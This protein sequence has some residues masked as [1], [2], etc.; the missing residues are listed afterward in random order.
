MAGVELSILMCAVWALSLSADA[1]VTSIRLVGGKTPFSGRLEVEHNRKWGTVCADEFTVNSAKVVCRMLGF[2]DTKYAEVVKPDVFGPGSGVI[3]L[4]SLTCHGNESDIS[5]CSHEPWGV[6]DCSPSEDIGVHCHTH[7]RLTSGSTTHDGQVEVNI[8]GIWEPICSENFTLSE[9]R[10]VCGMMGFIFN[11]AELKISNIARYNFLPT[12]YTCEGYEIDVSMCEKINITCS[13]PYAAFV[14]CRTPIRLVNG[15]S[16]QSGRVEVEYRG[17]WGTICDDG[18]DDLEAKVI[19]RMLDF[20]DKGAKSYGRAYF[21]AGTGPVTI[22]EMRCIGTENDI[23]DCK[24]S[25]WLSSKNCGH[26]EDASVECKTEVRL[27]NGPT[28]FS[29]RLEIS[30]GSVWKTVCSD[31][32]DNKTAMVVCKML[33]FVGGNISVYDDGRF[34]SGLMKTHGYDCNGNETDIVHCNQ[35]EFA[36][37]CSNG[38]SVGF[39]CYAITPIRLLEGTAMFNGRIEIYQRENSANGDWREICYNHLTTKD[40]M[41]MCRMIGHPTRYP[42]IHHAFNQYNSD[43]RFPTISGFGCSG[44]ETDITEC[45]PDKEWT[46]TSCSYNY[47]AAINCGINSTVRVMDGPSIKAG[48]VEVL[49]NGTWLGICNQRYNYDI[50]STDINL[51]CRH[52]GFNQS[53]YLT[54]PTA[55]RSSKVISK[56]AC[57]SSVSDVSDCRSGLWGVV[58]SCP[59]AAIVCNS[60]IRLVNGSSERSGRVEVLH[61]GMWGTVCADGFN[62]TEADVVCRK[63]GIRLWNASVLDDSPFGSGAHG[64]LLNNVS[65]KSSEHDIGECQSSPWNETSCED[66]NVATVLCRVLE[67]PIRLLGGKTPFDGRVELH[68]KNDWKPICYDGYNGKSTDVLCRLLQYNFSRDATYSSNSYSSNFLLENLRCVGN[69]S[70]IS[71]CPSSDWG[72]TSC[73]NY[74]LTINCLSPIF[75]Y[76]GS[77]SHSGFVNV[78]K[79]GRSGYMCADNLT[80]E[81]QSVICKMLF[82][83]TRDYTLVDQAYFKAGF[84]SGSFVDNI[85]CTG[86]EDDYQMCP[87]SDWF[88]NSKCKNPAFLRCNT[89]VRLRDGRNMYTGNVEVYI[90]KTWSNVCF[91]PSRNAVNAKM[92]CRM[93]GYNYRLAL[94]SNMTTR[95]ISNLLLTCGGSADDI[96]Q[97]L[98]INETNCASILSISCPT[99]LQLQNGRTRYMGQIIVQL[100]DYESTVNGFDDEQTV[101]TICRLLGFNFTRNYQHS[102]TDYLRQKTLYRYALLQK[103]KCFGNETDIV[104]C[105]ESTVYS[106]STGTYYTHGISCQTP[107]QLAKGN[108]FLSGKLEVNVNKTWL[109]VCSDGFSSNDAYVICRMLGHTHA[110]NATISSEPINGTLVDGGFSCNGVE[111]DISQCTGY[112]EKTLVECGSQMAIHINCQTMVRLADGP[113]LTKGRVEVF[114]NGTWGP[115][116]QDT[117]SSFVANIICRSAGFRYTYGEVQSTFTYSNKTF[118]NYTISRLMCTRYEETI[119]EC[120]SN[121]WMTGSCIY[122][123]P[124]EVECLTRTSLQAGVNKYFGWARLEFQDPYGTKYGTICG[125]GFFAKE[126]D[127]IC[128][129]VGAPTNGNATIY[130][131]NKFGSPSYRF[132]IEQLN[133][134]GKENDLQECQSKPWSETSHMCTSSNKAVAINCRPNTPIRLRGNDPNKGMVE[135]FFD[136]AWYLM[137]AYTFSFREAAVVCNKLGYKIGTPDIR[138]GF[139]ENALIYDM[140]CQGSETDISQCQFQRQTGYTYSW[141]PQ[142]C[143]YHG[144]TYRYN[145]AGVICSNNR[146]RLISNV[147]NYQ[148]RVEFQYFGVW[149]TVCNKHFDQGDARVVCRLAGIDS[150]GNFTIYTNVSK[151]G[152]GSG[153]LIV[154]D[155][156]CNGTESDIDECASYPW[157][158]NSAHT[159][160]NS[161]SL[162]VGVN[163]RPVT[164]MRL[165][166]GTNYS[167]RVEI[168]YEGVW[169]T[170]CDRGFDINDAKVICRMKGFNTESI[171]IR[172]NGFYGNGNGRIFISDLLC[173]GDEPD[174]SECNVGLRWKNTNTLCTN[175]NDVAVQCNT[176]VRVRDGLTF[177]SGIAEVYIFGGWRRICKDNFTIQDALT[178]CTLAGKRDNYNG[179]VTIHNQDFVNMP[180]E[181]TPIGDF[182]CNSNEEDLYECG[183]GQWVKSSTACPSGE[184]VALNCRAQ[185]PV[186]LMEGL[187]EAAD[188]VQKPIKGRVEVQY[189]RYDQELQKYRDDHWG[190]ICDDEFGDDDALVLCSMMGYSVGKVYRPHEAYALFG[191]ETIILDDLQCLGV[192]EDVS[193]CKAREWGT[194]DCL[195]DENVAIYCNYQENIDPCDKENYKRLPNLELRLVNY[196]TTSKPIN[197]NK[198]SLNWYFVGNNT[199][200]DKEPPFNRCATVFPVYSTDPIPVLGAGVKSLKAEQTGNSSITYDIQAKNCGSYFVYRLGPTKTKDSGYCFGIGSEIPPP[201]FVARSVITV[202]ENNSNSVWFRCKFDPDAEH[203]LTYQVQWHVSG[204]SEHILTKQYCQNTNMHPCFLPE[205]EFA[206][207]HVGMGTNVSC[208]VRAFNEAG[209][210][211]GQLSVFSETYF[212][213]IKLLTPYVSVRRGEIKS[214]EL[215]FTVPIFCRNELGCKA[216]L[217]Y[218]TP[219][220]GTNCPDVEGDFPSGCSQTVGAQPLGKI[221]NVDVGAA[222]TG[223]YGV[224]GKFTL[225]LQMHKNENVAFLYV[226]YKLPAI[227]VEILPEADRQWQGK[228]C[229]ARNDPHMYTFDGRSYE[230]HTEEGDYILYKHT[231]YENIEIQHR[232]ANCTDGK[233]LAKCNCGVA[234]RAGRDVYVINVCNGYI[235]IGYRQCWDKALTVK[236]END[237]TYTIYLPYGTAVRAR[238]DNAPFMGEAGGRVLDISVN[239]SNKD[240][241]GNST[242]LCGSLNNDQS[243]DFE[244]QDAFIN[245][246]KVK[247]NASLFASD[248]YHK[249]LEPWVFPTCSCKKNSIGNN[250][251]TCDRSLTGCTRGT[252]TGYRSC[253][254]VTNSRPVRSVSGHVKQRRMRIPVTHQRSSKKSLTKRSTSTWTV[255]NA[256]RHC[257]TQLATIQTLC[258]NIPNTHTDVSVDNCALDI[259][260]A[261]STE[262]LSMS[263]QSMLETC[264]NEIH[265][266]STVIRHLIDKAEGNHTADNNV[267][268]KEELEKLQFLLQIGQEIEKKFCI[269]NCNGR[270]QC[271]NGTCTCELNY[272]AIDCSMNLTKPPKIALM[273]DGLCD[274]NKTDCSDIVV[275]GGEF[276]SSNLTCRLKWFSV[277]INGSVSD[278]Q[279]VLVPGEAETLGTA[280]CPANRLRQRR[281]SAN[282]FVRGF[283]VSIS[284]DGYNF[285]ENQQESV[286]IYNSECQLYNTNSETASKFTFTLKNEYCFIEDKCYINGTLDV[287][288]DFICDPAIEKTSWTRYVPPLDCNNP[289]ACKTISNSVCE[290]ISDVANCNCKRGYTLEK[291]VCK[292]IDSIMDDIPVSDRHGSL[293]V[294]VTLDYQFP[295]NINIDS[296]FTF[297]RYKTLLVDELSSFYKN[298]LGNRL[299]K[300]NIR[301]IKIGSLIVDHRVIFVQREHILS[302]V[303]QAVVKLFQSNITIMDQNARIINVALG[304]DKVAI[305]HGNDAK[306][307]AFTSVNPCQH[308]EECIIVEGV[309][310]CVKK[311]TDS[312]GIK[313]SV[314]VGSVVGSLLFLVLVILV[315]VICK[316]YSRSSKAKISTANLQSVD[317]CK[318]PRPQM[319]GSELVS[320]YNSVKPD[321]PK[322]RKRYVQNENT[323]GSFPGYSGSVS[324][325]RF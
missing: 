172:L 132:V 324:N 11:G 255:E 188:I 143:W 140:N 142:D 266:N 274:T 299:D 97:C 286:F 318:I 269:N 214:I 232:I 224:A 55:T 32:V 152:Q 134:S 287:S 205:K 12:S 263:R 221:L 244:N 83:V 149:G 293:V 26:N 186:R 250:D 309:L 25:E 163:C 233:S 189:R 305:N 157:K 20:S 161:H 229:G 151:F 70:D 65:C 77:N 148:G 283:R 225:F 245:M 284:N 92:F 44:N 291:D 146:V 115:V 292:K 76:G 28:K 271:T 258:K 230:H 105:L 235:D 310:R 158:A 182:G 36:P 9:A 320:E 13:Q 236:K 238:I 41:V 106:E 127:V 246:W 141:T 87:S 184:N 94:S 72:Y 198:L 64:Y 52:M 314:I 270:G 304:E 285:N 89:P 212:V 288:K 53:G 100:G 264:Q 135:V 273:N 54:T 50:T 104:E 256:R 75:L 252:L 39:N 68:F 226:P 289:E 222:E 196:K 276:S 207:M 18:F 202:L 259:M 71:L 204:N 2:T 122:S 120:S 308:D 301:D 294:E 82:N 84:A 74:G 108:S 101:G 272:G 300:V 16:A 19:C 4:D 242:G 57:S 111:D 67:T 162:D 313:L 179:N 103:L 165:V 62:V 48:R 278:D 80:A 21:G 187:Q 175:T 295:E 223:Q 231:K 190:T 17:M 133:C 166:G 191:N 102:S 156:H 51:L 173:T 228:L 10:V 138:S 7:M 14:N 129:I 91:D 99:S 170:I 40:A 46:A 316:K 194:H 114:Y 200:P 128:N 317:L 23:S 116:C 139:S 290:V 248:M 192:E 181:Y 159:P 124:L 261:N 298:E 93:L 147:N 121:N 197:D 15:T 61:R 208:A 178:L 267:T 280:I 137:C 119:T 118:S 206:D 131:N 168:E 240:T 319:T 35:N 303:T 257:E 153:T 209:G 227:E 60:S 125:S 203:N 109:P 268:T 160:C 193:E 164:P 254:E 88:S 56:L 171:E 307:R 279:T 98:G 78:Q 219:D 126:A 315:G 260:L 79:N 150:A 6:S 265:R 311:T 275:I 95:N 195:H 5:Q 47:R 69:E 213:G 277:D 96:S 296:A 322:N 85:K 86:I 31:L 176:P 145:R 253:N 174:I 297:E 216:T 112:T 167:G 251:Y 49:Y 29:G 58:D 218:F 45:T 249:D 239:P 281:S 1:E 201:A 63:A 321:A 177:Y 136:G 33:G 110:R 247:L 43:G 130:S 312:E 217:D 243:D 183:S 302:D 199:L 117:T 66:G 325:D 169:G 38:T 155:L 22:N 154:E 113:S 30:T 210:Q 282:T 237:Y 34:G 211:P 81:T 37:S 241:N 107:I 215:Q 27:V 8:S 59:Q 180:F 24:S 3:M 144:A 73:S 42:T 220:Y 234:V 185:T 306:C 323:Y 123:A 262:W 90:N